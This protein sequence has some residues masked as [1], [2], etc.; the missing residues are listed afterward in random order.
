MGLLSTQYCF[1]ESRSVLFAFNTTSKSRLYG[2]NTCDI[3]D[4]RH[5]VSSKYISVVNEN[6]YDST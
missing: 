1:Y 4:N 2:T 6:I 3:C 5:E